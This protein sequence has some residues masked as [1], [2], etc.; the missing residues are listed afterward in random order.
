MDDLPVAPADQIEDYWCLAREPLNC[1][2]FLLPLLAIYELGVWWISMDAARN[3]ADYWMRGFLRLAGFEHPALLP[4]LVIGLLAGWHIVGRFR[5]KLSPATLLG[6]WAESALFGVCLVILGQ[7]QDLAFHSHAAGARRLAVPLSPPGT[8]PL[9]ISYLGAGVYE[10][11]LFRVCLFKLGCGAFR[12]LLVPRQ[13]AVVFSIIGTSLLFS[14][15]HYIGPAADEFSLFTFFFRAMAGLF[16]S[17][18]FVWR[19][20][21]ISVGSHAAYDLMVGILIPAL[22]V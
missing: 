20:F 12:V 4:F 9:V 10:E 1:L 21:G 3:G 7:L 13:A 5:W 19:G 18:L 8:L 15:A 16:F 17:A 22:A 14:A 11:V 6:M 2:L